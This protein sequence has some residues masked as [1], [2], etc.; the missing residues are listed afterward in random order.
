MA[1]SLN[2][3]LRGRLASLIWLAC[4]AGSLAGLA[5]AEMLIDPTR[6][7]LA[8]RGEG[9]GVATENQPVAVAAATRVQKIVRGPGEGHTAL[10]DG[11]NVR[12]GDTVRVAGGSARVE[13]ITDTSVVLTR[14][15]SRET[16]QLIPGSERSVQCARRPESQRPSGC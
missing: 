8:H 5:R 12:V 1:A 14:G 15:D 2:Q 16:L 3:M 10:I 4:F 13:R 11:N 6:S 7:P 9:V